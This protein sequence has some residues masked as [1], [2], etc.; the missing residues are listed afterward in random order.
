MKKLFFVPA[1]LLAVGITSCGNN[2]ENNDAN[3][4]TESQ[5][6]TEETTVDVETVPGIDDLTR[7]NTR[8]VEGN[9]K[10]QFDVNLINV[11]AGKTVE[12]TLKNVGSMSIESM[13]HN[14]VI[15]TPGTDIAT[16]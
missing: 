5:A 11:K 2:A 8:G 15:L 3:T 1:F 4:S 13:G 9:D 7:C 14:L 10:M 16:F 12:I 6:T